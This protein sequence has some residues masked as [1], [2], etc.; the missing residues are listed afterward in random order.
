MRQAKEE[1][2]MRQ[3][4]EEERIKVVTGKMEMG[5]MCRM[6]YMIGRG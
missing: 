4:K 6:S 2:R 3:A 5:E 1:Q